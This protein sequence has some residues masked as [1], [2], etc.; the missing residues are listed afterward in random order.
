MN[1]ATKSALLLFPLLF[2]AFVILLINAAQ[3][4][5]DLAGDGITYVVR[6]ADV[7]VEGDDL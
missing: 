5:L 6:R 1:P 7:W 4:V 2:L 3:S